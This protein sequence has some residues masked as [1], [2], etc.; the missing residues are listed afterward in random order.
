MNILIFAGN[1]NLNVDFIKKYISEDMFIIACD[2][3]LDI[4]DKLGVIPNVIIGDMDSVNKDLLIADKYKKT[5]II[6]FN[7]DKDFTD[8]DLVLLEVQKLDLEY[9]NIYIFGATN[10][11]ADHYMANIFLLQKY[12]HLKNLS[13]VDEINKI[14]VVDGAKR[15]EK[16]KKY[17]SL[18]PLTETVNVTLEGVKYPLDMHTVKKMQTLMISNEIVSDYALITIHHGIVLVIE[19][20]TDLSF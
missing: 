3:G 10:G 5:K 20:D 11:R 19:A 16:S 9:E 15:V 4:I 17:L 8:L 6:R 7:E 12:L 14:Y 13:L 1:K 18:I 2:G